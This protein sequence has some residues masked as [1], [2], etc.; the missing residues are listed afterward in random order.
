[1]GLLAAVGHWDRPFYPG[2][3]R[4]FSTSSYASYDSESSST[5]NGH[6]H[7]REGIYG[8]VQR[9]AEDWRVFWLGDANS[10]LDD[11]FDDEE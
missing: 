5:M 4:S 10:S 6:Q 3:S 11:D 7:K 1:M 9:G 2:L 8:W